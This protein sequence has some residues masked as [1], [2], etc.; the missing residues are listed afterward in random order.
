MSFVAQRVKNLGRSV[1]FH[2]VYSPSFLLRCRG[3][4]LHQ[5][6][7]LVTLCDSRLRK[8]VKH[9]PEDRLLPVFFF[10]GEERSKKKR[11]LGFFKIDRSGWERR[12]V[13]SGS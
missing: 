11:I 8:L 7:Y 9:V 10:G 13:R 1:A 12:E 4:T 2:P 3:P 5:E 6:I